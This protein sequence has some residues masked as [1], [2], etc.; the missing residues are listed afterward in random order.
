MRLT[1]ALATF[2]AIAL[3]API[4]L[5]AAEVIFDL[6]QAFPNGMIENGDLA[7]LGRALDA[8][9]VFSRTHPTVALFDPMSAKRE[10]LMNALRLTAQKKVPFMLDVYTSAA[11]SIGGIMTPTSPDADPKRG[12]TASVEFLSQLR[13]DPTIGPY[14]TGLRF[15]EVMA[16][17][18]SVKTCL[19]HATGPNRVNW[20]DRIWVN[21][22]GPNFFDPAIATAYLDFARANGMT[23][24]WSDWKWD[25]QTESQQAML[26]RILQSQDYSKTVV[27]GYSNNRPNEANRDD[28]SGFDA[29]VARHQPWVGKYIKGIGLSEQAWVCDAVWTCPTDVMDKWARHGLDAHVDI[30]QFEPAGYFFDLPHGKTPPNYQDDPRWSENSGRP[31]VTLTTL[32][33]TLGVDVSAAAMRPSPAVADNPVCESFSVPVRKIGLGERLHAVGRVIVEGAK[34]APDLGLAANSPWEGAVRVAHDHRGA[35]F[36]V[37]V[38][39]TGTPGWRRLDIVSKVDGAE[40]PVCSLLINVAAR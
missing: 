31:K 33:R 16:G 30:L 36:E 9:K 13:K 12:T 7:G 20:C 34:S 5:R 15:F 29:W 40:Q 17:D 11:H 2:G 27:L 14:F 26:E 6:D 38:E 24:F 10:N 23:V 32:A 37:D 28:F 39:D 8:L 4:Q 1:I 21:I 35:G 22:D 19:A 25:V 18:F 3:L